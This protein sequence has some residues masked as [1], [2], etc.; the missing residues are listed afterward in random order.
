MREGIKF[1]DKS[2]FKDADIIFVSD[3]D[4]RVSETFVTEVMAAK[5]EK[6]FSAWGIKITGG[7][8]YRQLDT[9]SKFC[10]DVKEISS[11]MDDG[12]ANEEI[13]DLLF[14]L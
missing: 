13:T 10:D 12:D 3:D 4:C 9:M 8:S 6:E 1:I 5:K 2:E 11:S 14:T 7:Y